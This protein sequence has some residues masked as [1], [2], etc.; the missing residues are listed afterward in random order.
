[1]ESQLAK[2]LEDGGVSHTRLSVL[3][4]EDIVSRCV[5][6]ALRK[7]HLE[8]LQQRV[9]VGQHAC[10]MKVWED[11]CG[12]YFDIIVNMAFNLTCSLTGC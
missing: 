4:A 3:E 12:K 6:V 2:L 8:S 10:L 5:F 9:T 7:E 11:S 1:M